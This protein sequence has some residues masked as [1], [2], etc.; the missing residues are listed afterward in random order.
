MPVYYFVTDSDAQNYATEIQNTF[1]RVGINT[2][3]APAELNKYSDTGIMIGSTTPDKPSVRAKN[4]QS[5]FSNCG[6]NPHFVKYSLSPILAPAFQ[7]VD[8]DVFVGP[9]D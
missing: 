7:K 9:A 3:M 1:L 4:L 6:F 5:I 8:F 2:G